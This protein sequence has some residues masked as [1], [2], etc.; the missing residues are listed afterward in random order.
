MMFGRII[1]ALREPWR[2]EVTVDYSL[3]GTSVWYGRRLTAIGP[4]GM[5]FRGDSRFVDGR[6][7]F[8][9]DIVPW[10]LLARPVE[11]KVH[12]RSKP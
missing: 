3:G 6:E 12:E 11:I 5:E 1:D 8:E 4:A 10:H 9:V 7:L 2:Y